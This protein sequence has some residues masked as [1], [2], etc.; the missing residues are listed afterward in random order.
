[1]L[2]CKTINI[3]YFIFFVTLLSS[4]ASSGQVNGINVIEENQEKKYTQIKT[5]VFKSNATIL[6]DTITKYNRYPSEQ[7][8]EQYIPS[9]S[10]VQTFEG[11][12]K[13]S[14]VSNDQIAAQDGETFVSRY[15]KFHRQYSGYIDKS[16]DTVLVVCF[17]DFS[18]RREGKKFFY[19][20]KYQNSFFGSV[21]YLHKKS[22]S[23]YCY[24][25]NKRTKQL[26]RYKI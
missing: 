19:D 5:S 3:S 4:C 18:N 8:I 25:L 12:L 2:S 11:I 9:L 7:A 22:P 13:S 23:I 14:F 20:W 10:D 15:K 26:S 21:L 6:K 1:M 17:L 24:A 16:A